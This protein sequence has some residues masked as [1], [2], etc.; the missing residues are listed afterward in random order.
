MK[1]KVPKELNP[2]RQRKA[3]G[4]ITRNTKKI[5]C[6]KVPAM[7]SAPKTVIY[8]PRKAPELFE[9]PRRTEA[10]QKDRGVGPGPRLRTSSF[11]VSHGRNE[12]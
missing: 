5:K 6:N 4:A 7:T 12:N 10:G 2:L 1:R 11:I 9:P 3:K 8:R